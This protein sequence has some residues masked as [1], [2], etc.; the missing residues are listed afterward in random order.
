MNLMFWKRDLAADDT[1]SETDGNTTQSKQRLI[2]AIAIGTFV[3]MA[4]VT[5]AWKVLQIS[6]KQHVAKIDSPTVIQPIPLPEKPL[7]KLPPIGLP[8]PKETQDKN[9]QFDLQTPNITSGA[10]KTSIE[11]HKVDTTRVENSSN[12]N[13]QVEIETLK[14]KN[15]ELQDQLDA[16]KKKQQQATALPNGQVTGSTKTNVRS[17][18]IAV[19]NKDSKAT[20]MTLKEAIEAMN[21]G[22]GDLPIKAGK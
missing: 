7:I 2:I 14:K 9:H 16:L 21:A 8:L 4:I 17:G 12:T 3:L 6:P 11:V 19:S 1:Q 22:S 10:S 5:V 15:N 18:N 20:A 13:T